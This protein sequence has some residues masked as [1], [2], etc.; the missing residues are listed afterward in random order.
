MRC[1]SIGL[2]CGVFLLAVLL[3][4]PSPA[5]ANPCAANPCAAKGVNPCA[6]KAA[7]P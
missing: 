3:G 4:F 6:A 1:R 2:I 5:G 7:N